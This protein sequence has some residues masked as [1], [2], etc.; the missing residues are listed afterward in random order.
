M[1]GVLL[2]CGLPCD[3]SLFMS[4]PPH[5]GLFEVPSSALARSLCPARDVGVLAVRKGAAE[6]F[7]PSIDRG[8]TC[9]SKTAVYY[10]T[11]F[12]HS[13]SAEGHRSSHRQYLRSLFHTP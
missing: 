8:R 13:M 9:T 1:I 10:G 3:L 7:R 5:I 2:P 12:G 11:T 4:I 6:V